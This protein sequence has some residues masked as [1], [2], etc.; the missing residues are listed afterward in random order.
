MHMPNFRDIQVF[1]F[2]VHHGN[3]YSVHV[4]NMNWHMDKCILKMYMYNSFFTRIYK[5]K[6]FTLMKQ[7]LNK[8][9][10][11]ELA[12]CKVFNFCICVYISFSF[13]KHS[14][15]SG[16]L[17]PSA[18][19]VPLFV[20]V[21]MIAEARRNV[22]IQSNVITMTGHFGDHMIRFLMVSAV[23]AISDKHSLRTESRHCCKLPILT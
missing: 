18:G 13:F 1:F 11:K 7:Y 21:L 3:K 19:I 6:F 15:D 10:K 23:V 17:F 8:R 2:L 14:R 22:Y 20:G 12:H 4:I 16:N 5:K 9:I